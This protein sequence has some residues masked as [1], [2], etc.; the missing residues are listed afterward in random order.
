MKLTNL[1]QFNVSYNQLEGLI[2]LGNR[3]STFS[4]QSYEG[5]P[6]LCGAPLAFQCEN[7]VNPNY[8]SSRR[9]IPIIATNIL[10][11]IGVVIGYVGVLVGWL[12]W[13]LTRRKIG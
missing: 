4:N 10:E 13:K 3:F 9:K 12:T 5:N 6:G 11:P 1:G 7:E 2:P 8:S